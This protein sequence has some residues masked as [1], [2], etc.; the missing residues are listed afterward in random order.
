MNA[1]ILILLA[2][3][4]VVLVRCHARLTQ[5]RKAID[6]VMAKQTEVAADVVAL[7]GKLDAA[8]VK[9]T[10]IGTETDGLQQKIKDLEDALANQ[11]NASPE[12]I[13]AVEG[14]K[15]SVVALEST[16]TTV[17]DKVIDPTPPA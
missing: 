17:D 16:L 2:V 1:M 11:D 8:T 5:L 12:L 10:K 14:V 15:A 7:G 6:K 9:L 4:L 3:I 13:A